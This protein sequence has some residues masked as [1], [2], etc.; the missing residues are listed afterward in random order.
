M[1][2]LDTVSFRSSDRVTKTAFFMLFLGSIFSKL[3]PLW[4]ILSPH[5]DKMA[6]TNSIFHLIMC[7]SGKKNYASARKSWD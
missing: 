1:L 4:N 5:G 6:S 3:A 2:V 7:N